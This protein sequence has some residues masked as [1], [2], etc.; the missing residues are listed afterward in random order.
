MTR[1]AAARAPS[2]RVYE[3]LAA[4]RAL[5][6]VLLV[7]ILGVVVLASLCSG[8]TD[9][10]PVR[11]LKALLGGGGRDSAVVWSLRAPRV[12][13]ALL[14]G[15]GLA[16][17]GATTQAILRNPLA[18]PFTLGVASGAAFGAALVILAGATQRWLPATSAFGFALLASLLVLGV[19]RLKSGGSGILILGGVAIMF[20]FS[21]MTSFIQYLGDEHQVR[22][23]VFWTFGSLSKACWP[24]IAVAAAMILGPLP[25]LLRRAW[26]LNVLAA[27]EDAARSMGVNVDVLRAGGVVLA[28]LMTA[29]AICFTGVVGFIGLVAPHIARMLIG[30]DHRFLLPACCLLGAALAALADLVGRLVWP[31]Q[32]IPI[33]IM[34][35]VIGAPF[36]MHLLLKR[37]R[38]Y[39]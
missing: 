13:M 1:E 26:D 35:A 30:G 34:T 33:G 36:F 17:G 12:A 38:E 9:M 31:P 3:A 10:G 18:S 22:A 14:V 4:R 23:I 27:G 6:L 39:W 19:S 37:R 7:L 2:G 28:A 20:L 32:V 5:V 29:G 11:V 25:L 24:D 8:A 16:S 21:S 15:A